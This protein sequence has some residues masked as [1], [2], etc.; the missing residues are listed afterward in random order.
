MCQLPN[1]GAPV[2]RGCKSFVLLVP[3]SLSF[4]GSMQGSDAGMCIAAPCVAPTK[5]TKHGHCPHW[6]ELSMCLGGWGCRGG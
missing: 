1:R 6:L 3:C 2:L 4:V 5:C